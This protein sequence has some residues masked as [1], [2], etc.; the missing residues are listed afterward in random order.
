MC[1][2]D[3]AYTSC[4]S[5]GIAIGVE[6]TPLFCFRSIPALAAVPCIVPWALCVR[7]SL[8][9][10]RRRL[11]MG[12]V[13][14]ACRPCL[15]HLSRADLIVMTIPCTQDAGWQS[16][17]PIDGVLVSEPRATCRSQAGWLFSVELVSQPLY[18][19][20]AAAAEQRWAPH[21]CTATVELPSMPWLTSAA[22]CNVG[23][24]S[25]LY[26]FTVRS[27]SDVS[28]ARRR[29][30]R[31]ACPKALPLWQRCL[32]IHAQCNRSCCTSCAW[33]PVRRCNSAAAAACPTTQVHAA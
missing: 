11:R 33:L 12:F 32:S 29:Y 8:P 19:A 30:A 13:P 18:P 3:A 14:T 21:R 4:N 22:A 10:G 16:L 1:S 2:C 27:F 23:S 20:L 24:G 6:L 5:E 28:P 15:S 17:A 25:L 31:Y 26:V 9:H 7:R